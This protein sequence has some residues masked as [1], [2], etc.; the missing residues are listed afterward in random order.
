MI[1][2]LQTYQSRRGVRSLAPSLERMFLTCPFD[3]LFTDR[4]LR[5]NLFIGI[6]F[7][8]QTAARGLLR[9]VSASSVACS[10]SLKKDTS[11]EN[12]LFS[13]R[14]PPELFPTVPCATDFFLADRPVRQL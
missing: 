12:R 2:R 10:A 1:P 13:R 11:G 5:C 7:G 14:V 9:V 4:K 8:D 6:P 3:G